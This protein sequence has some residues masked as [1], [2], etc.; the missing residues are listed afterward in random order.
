MMYCVSL[1]ES[2]PA[3]EGVEATE[4]ECIEVLNTIL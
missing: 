1:Q 3:I 2:S 4:N